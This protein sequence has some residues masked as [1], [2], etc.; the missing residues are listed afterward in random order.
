MRRIKSISKMTGLAITA[1]LL[2][3]VLLAAI[4]VTIA[5]SSRAGNANSAQQ[6]DKLTATTI[7]NQAQQF[8]TAFEL[9]MSNGADIT[10]ITATW[11]P[12]SGTQ[13]LIFSPASASFP[14]LTPPIAGSGLANH[15]SWSY[16]WIWHGDG[17][18]VQIKNVGT[19]VG[20]YVLALAPITLGVCQQINQ[21]LSGDASIPAIT[22][23]WYDWSDMEPTDASNDPAVDGKQ[24][25]CF[26]DNGYDAYEYYKVTLVQ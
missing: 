9:A 21:L 20:N 19:G 6:Q 23:S 8:K 13:P 25:G 1:I 3:V 10:S 22:S 4:A 11:P 5:M 2:A 16:A 24:E 15:P 18:L 7:M 17:H 14:T 12:G 26:A